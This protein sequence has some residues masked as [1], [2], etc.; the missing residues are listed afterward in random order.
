MD[1]KKT[2]K[3]QPVIFEGKKIRRCWDEEKELWYFAVMDAV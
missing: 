3:K 1:N 2:N